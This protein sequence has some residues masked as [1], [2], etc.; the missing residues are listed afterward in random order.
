M[1]VFIDETGVDGNICK[2]RSWC[3]KG[4]ILIGK[5]TERK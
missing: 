4:K 5:K 1:L 3:K 2:E